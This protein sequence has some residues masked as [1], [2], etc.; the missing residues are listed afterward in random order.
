MVIE[1]GLLFSRRGKCPQRACKQPFLGKLSQHHQRLLKLPSFP[2]LLAPL[3]SSGARQSTVLWGLARRSG[4]LWLLG[5]WW[6]YLRSP[7]HPPSWYVDKPEPAQ[8]QHLVHSSLK[9]LSGKHLVLKPFCSFS[10]MMTSRKVMYHLSIHTC[11]KYAVISGQLLLRNG[12][13]WWN[14]N[15]SSLGHYI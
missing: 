3:G 10:W 12:W 6:K 11:K 4:W 1:L 2:I 7:G 9:C 15:G 14:Y 8:L 5:S 13:A